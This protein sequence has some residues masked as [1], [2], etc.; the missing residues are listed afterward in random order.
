MPFS[1]YIM[2]FQGFSFRFLVYD[3]FLVPGDH[4]SL[5]SWSLIL[6][7]VPVWSLYNGHYYQLRTA[8]NS[9]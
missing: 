4:C 3:C 7:V 5:E 2:S 1:R 6:G 9:Q 8:A